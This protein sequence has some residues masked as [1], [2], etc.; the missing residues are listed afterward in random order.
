M[1]SERMGED[2][3]DYHLGHL[4]EP[5]TRYPGNPILTA[6]DM[7]YPANSVF[8]AGATKIGDNTLLLMRV[9]DRRGLSHLTVARSTDGFTSWQIDPRP[10]LPADPDG[11][12]EEVWGIEDAP[13]LLPR[14]RRTLHHHLYG[15]LSRRPARIS[16]DHRGLRAF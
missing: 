1:G 5:F 15:I 3:G 11:H 13:H 10:T 7:P 2:T 16:C 9:E 14:G 12:P 4:E 8:N 6:K